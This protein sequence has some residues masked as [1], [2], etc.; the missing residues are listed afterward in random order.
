MRLSQAKASVRECGVENQVSWE[1]PA[2][3]TRASC[4][5]AYDTQAR[6]RGPARHLVVAVVA[7]LLSC[8]VLSG[9]VLQTVPNTTLTPATEEKITKRAGVLTV[10]VNGSNT[11]YGGVNS[12]GDLIGLDVDLAA[13]LADEMGYELQIVD[14]SSN[15]RSAIEDRQAD[16]VLGMTK[17]GDDDKVTYSTAYLDD[18]ATLFT[19]TDNAVESVT[20]VKL[21]KSNIIVQDDTDAA[22]TVE[23]A[24]GIEKVDVTSTLQEA[25]EAL[26]AGEEKYLVTDAVIGS[27]FARDYDDVVRI[28]YIGSS[29]ITPRYAVTLTKREELTAAVDE[30]M[31]ALT[32]NGRLRVVAS[33]WLGSEAA[34]LLA[35]ATDT[36]GLPETAFGLW[37]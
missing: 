5:F 15:G 3:P 35:G 33:K 25:F 20:D 1:E 37:G 32:E 11:P 17:S 26:E 4:L 31:I 7:A 2:H 12:D 36:T 13:A 23:G 27:Y 18:G 28:G 21:N 14:V 29:C 24:V 8:I 9:C 34:A 22:S 6:W 19:L 10:G 16:V 30:A